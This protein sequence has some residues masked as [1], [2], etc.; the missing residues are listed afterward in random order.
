[1]SVA[2][3]VQQHKNS[4]LIIFSHPNHPPF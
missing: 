4:A 1:M 3:T 2:K